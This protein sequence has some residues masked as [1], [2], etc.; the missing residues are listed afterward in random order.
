MNVI[1]HVVVLLVIFEEIDLVADVEEQLGKFTLAILYGIVLELA[2]F[3][4]D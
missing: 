4:V 1:Q 2:G 3:V